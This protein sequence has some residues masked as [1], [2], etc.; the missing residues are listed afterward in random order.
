PS[1]E[2]DLFRNR[3]THSLEL[4]QISKS[5]ADKLKAEHELNLDYDLIETSA[6]CHDIGHPPYCHNR[7]VALNKKMLEYGGFETNEQT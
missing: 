4:A 1:F 3:L 7:E 5:I 6:L 2:N